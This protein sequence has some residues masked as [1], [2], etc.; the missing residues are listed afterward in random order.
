MEMNVQKTTV[1]GLSRQTSPVQIMID[2]KQLQDVEYFN[3]LGIMITNDAT[4][5]RE[6]KSRVSK[7]RA[8][9]DKKKTR[10]TSKFGLDLRKKVL[11]CNIWS[12]ALYGAETW[13]L[14]KVDR[15]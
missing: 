3:C 11:N 5:K 12:I 4:C 9:V 6:I 10:F 7:E 13:T 2:E 8:A 14:R 15:K 1:M